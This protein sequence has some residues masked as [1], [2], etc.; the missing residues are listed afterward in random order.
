M[1]INAPLVS[2]CSKDFLAFR[3]GQV[4]PPEKAGMSLLCGA[5]SCV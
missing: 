5:H 3:V 1:K 4:D 2:L